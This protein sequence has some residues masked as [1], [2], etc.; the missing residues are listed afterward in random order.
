MCV[1]QK[2]VLP[3]LGVH[4]SKSPF[5]KWPCFQKRT[6]LKKKDAN[7]KSR[8]FFLGQLCFDGSDG[9]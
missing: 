6:H 9:S 8:V 2:N 5:D 1:A 4:L 3:P 7:F